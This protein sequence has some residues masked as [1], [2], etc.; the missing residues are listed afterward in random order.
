MPLPLFTPGK[1][2]VPIVEEAGW[3]LGPVWTGAENLAPTGIRSPDRPARSQSL[4]RLRYPASP[5][6]KTERGTKWL[7]FCC[8]CYI[9]YYY[10]HHHHYYYY[11]YHHHHYYY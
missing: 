3:V 1:D 10:Y 8:C 11:Y 5:T 7:I 9:Y 6:M 4:H 2:P